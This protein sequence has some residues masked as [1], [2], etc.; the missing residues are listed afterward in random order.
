MSTTSKKQSPLLTGILIFIVILLGWLLVRDLFDKKEEAHKPANRLTAAD[1]PP[2]VAPVAPIVQ[3][4][5]QPSPTTKRETAEEQP[6]AKPLEIGTK[7]IT[8][9]PYKD[10]PLR[11][12]EGPKERLK[13][14][15]LPPLP[16]QEGTNLLPPE[17]ET[18]NDS[19]Q[20]SKP[21]AT[22]SEPKPS[23]DPFSAPPMQVDVKRY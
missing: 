15:E 10:V 1:I 17:D 20:Y 19:P 6:P 9:A 11:T 18:Y 7:A 12:D 8:R 16:E 5:A 21:L 4:A 22:P 2:P 3:E 23:P 14:M 13:K